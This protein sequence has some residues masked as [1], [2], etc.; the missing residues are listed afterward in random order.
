LLTASITK[1]SSGSILKIYGVVNGIISSAQQ[2]TEVRLR[3]DST[4]LMGGSLDEAANT[5]S[6]CC[7]FVYRATGI[8]SGAH[9][10]TIQVRSINVGQSIYVRPSTY[11]DRESAT[12]LVEEI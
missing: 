2:Q 6:A 9:T 1:A 3:I 11:P 5:N 4:V 7:S 8:S 10:V 12:L